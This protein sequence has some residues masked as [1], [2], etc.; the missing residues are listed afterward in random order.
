MKRDRLAPRLLGRR[1]PLPLVA[2]LA[3]V[4]VTLWGDLTAGNVLGGLV[5]GLVVTWLLPLPILDPGIRVW[6]LALVRFLLWF[7]WDMVISTARVVFWVAHPGP[8]PTRIV[9][10]PLRT[11]SEAMTVLVMIAVSTVPG[12]LVVEAYRRELVVHV[13]GVTGDVTTKI[14]AEVAG[15][16]SRIVRAFGTRRDREELE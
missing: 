15:L 11:S 2:W 4:W 7:A 5:T 9:R 14:R 13:L 8:P 3:A 16:E 12:S 1:V 10:V 6:P